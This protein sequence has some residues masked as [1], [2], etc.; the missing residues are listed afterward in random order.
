MRVGIDTGHRGRLSKPND[1]GATFGGR[2]ESDMV[3]RYALELEIE[4]VAAGAT[5]FPLRDGEYSERAARSRAYGL[6]VVVACHANASAAHTADYARVL[7]YPT[8][9]AG[10]AVAQAVAAVLAPVV[11]WPCQAEAATPDRWPDACAIVARYTPPA[12][13][14]EPGFVDG[15][16][17]RVWLAD[18]GHLRELGRAVARGLTAWGR[19]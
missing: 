4:L 7:H 6:D 19:R 10:R 13:C 8:S 2:T 17:G 11:P 12:I 14:L 9:V 15:P 18:E 16:T 5:V 1:P 3:A